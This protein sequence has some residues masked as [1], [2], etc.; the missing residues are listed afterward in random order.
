MRSALMTIEEAAIYL[1]MSAQTLRRYI[2]NN[3]IAAIKFKRSYR[4]SQ[5]AIN[6][7]LNNKLLKSGK[8]MD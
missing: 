8:P 1:N 2:R 3:E 5:E 4:I 6:E 7:F